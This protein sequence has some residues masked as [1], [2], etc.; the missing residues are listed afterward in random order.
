[1][2][3]CNEKFKEEAGVAFFEI[4][5]MNEIKLGDSN[6]NNFVEACAKLLLP[7][8]FCKDL[9]SMSFEEFYKLKISSITFPIFFLRCL[10][11]LG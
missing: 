7:N 10:L 3:K 9:H 4:F 1:M 8:I 11:L 5:Y 6:F 2:Q